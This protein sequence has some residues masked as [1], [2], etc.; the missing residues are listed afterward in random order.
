[1]RALALVALAACS[2]PTK[3]FVGSDGSGKADARSD[4]ALDALAGFECVGRPFPTTAPSTI[5]VSG[6][7]LDQSGA[8]PV[9]GVNVIVADVSNTMIGGPVITSASGAYSIILTTPGTPLDAHVVAT[10]TSY[11]QTSV[12][13]SVPLAVDTD[14]SF[15]MVTSGGANAV[16]N[17]VGTTYDTTKAIVS[18]YLTDCDNKTLAGATM[19]NPF[20]G[21][22]QRY[23]SGGAL[24]ASATSTDSSGT[25]YFVNAPP[26]MATLSATLSTGG[27]EYARVVNPVG[28]EFIYS[29]LQPGP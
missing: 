21:S 1:M 20:A 22:T 28:G 17:A 2:F 25:V 10:G 15:A 4:V 3:N 13:R 27:A 9:A 18:V 12:W 23:Q 11:I 5:T 6:T 26:G 7:V 16:S 24:P 8:T 14:V 29:A 19:T